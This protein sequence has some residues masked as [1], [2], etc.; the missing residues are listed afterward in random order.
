MCR[1]CLSKKSGAFLLFCVHALVLQYGV[2]TCFLSCGLEQR[3]IILRELLC[4]E[5]NF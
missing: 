2:L 5:S 4:L 3:Q 1:F